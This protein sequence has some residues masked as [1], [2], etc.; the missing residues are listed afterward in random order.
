[1]VALSSVAG[2]SSN[3]TIGIGRF[4]DILLA[5]VLGTVSIGN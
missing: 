1:M 2:F 4:S 3:E 5:L